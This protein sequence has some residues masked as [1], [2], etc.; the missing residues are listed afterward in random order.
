MFAFAWGAIRLNL[1]GLPANPTWIR[2]YGV[3]ILCGVGFTMSLFIGLF[4]RIR[5]IAGR[6]QGRRAGGIAGV[7]A[8]RRG[9]SK[10]DGV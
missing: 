9:P 10:P 1:A 5:G 2:V 3:A 4:R 7:G 6:D 8:R